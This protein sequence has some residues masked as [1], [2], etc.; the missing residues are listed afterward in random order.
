[1]QAYYD[2]GYV[3][4]RPDGQ[5]YHPGYFTHRLGILIKRSQLPPIRLHDLRHGAASLAHGAGADLKIIQ[6]QLGHS[7][8]DTTADV[9]TSVLPAAQHEAAAATAE[10]IRKAARDRRTA[11][12]RAARKAAR[13]AKKSEEPAKPDQQNDSK[14]PGQRHDDH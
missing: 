7:R 5:P 12:R 3:F 4:T 9:Y 13:T 14:T 10:L 11:I 2:T 8:I 6:A 1:M